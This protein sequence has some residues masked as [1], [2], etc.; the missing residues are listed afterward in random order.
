MNLLSFKTHSKRDANSCSC[1]AALQRPST[2]SAHSYLPL[3]LVGKCGQPGLGL[4]LGIVRLER[5]RFGA[6]SS[7][8][9]HLSAGIHQH[10]SESKRGG[11]PAARACARSSLTSFN[12]PSRRRHSDATRSSTFVRT[13]GEE[14][15]GGSVVCGHRNAAR[16]PQWGLV[17]AAAALSPEMVPGPAALSYRLR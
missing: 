15:G 9:V 4:A 7:H 6:V 5:C 1:C 3:K 11:I 16:R 14:G 10:H 12:S 17:H 2:Q 13:R 8:A